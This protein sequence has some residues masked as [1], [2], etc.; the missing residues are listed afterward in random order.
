ME[1]TPE[2]ASVAVD[3]RYLIHAL[4]ELQLAVRKLSLYSASHALVPGLM[5]TLQKHFDAIFKFS[6]TVSLGVAK[7]E[8][9]YQGAPLTKDH[10]VIRELSRSLNQLNIAGLTFRKGLSKEELL[11]FLKLFSESRGLAQEEKEDLLSRWQNQSPSISLKLVSFGSAI[12]RQKADDPTGGEEKT[13]AA[14]EVWRGLAKQ[15]TPQNPNEGDLDPAQLAELV[16]QLHEQ[17]PSTAQSYE[18][19]IFDYLN[20]QARR[21]AFTEERFVEFNRQL[22]VFLSNLRPDVRERIYK[23]GLEET[24]EGGTRIEGLLEGL[25]EPV[26][27]EILNQ[28]QV[29]GQGVSGPMFSLLQKFMNL[30]DRDGKLKELLA[31]KLENSKD[32]L[33]D[34]MVD[35]SDRQYYPSSYRSLLDEEFAVKPSSEQAGARDL[36]EEGTTHHFGLV[37]LEL[38]EDHTISTTQYEGIVQAVLD[39]LS[40]AKKEEKSA[41][42]LQD[43]LSI[44]MRRLGGA[45]G[46]ERRFFL[47]QIKKFMRPEILGGLARKRPEAGEDA[48]TDVFQFLKDLMGAEMVPVLLDTLEEEDNLSARKR[49]LEMIVQFGTDVT[50][51][52]LQ[53]LQSPKWYVVRNMLVLLRDLNAKEA[54]DRIAQHARHESPQIRLVA[55]QALEKMGENTDAFFEALS[56]GLKDADPKVFRKAVSL[57][58]A[59]QDRRSLDMIRALLEAPDASQGIEPQLLILQA[60]RKGRR[61]DCIP[62]LAHLKR[63]LWLRFWQWGQQRA[64]Y[65][66]VKNTLEEIS[67]GEGIAHA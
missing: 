23:M 46:E 16:N 6:E 4:I 17:D 41:G 10:P 13:T 67:A 26:L 22:N 28:V 32:L 42:L 47:E 3:P 27:M 29:S 39:L 25:P 7:D 51:L 19:T 62:F 35:R 15:L 37:L 21:Q 57:L 36:D 31:S 14:R 49:L 18:I 30:S 20:D 48:S 9:L 33:E 5:N 24:Q 53:R 60:I 61:G 8:I 34:L 56:D 38:L 63:R 11:S 66:A 54:L 12:K 59:S 65:K 45:A 52:A 58:V 55:L 50:P 2:T 40:A 1:E 44:L 64:L 43:A